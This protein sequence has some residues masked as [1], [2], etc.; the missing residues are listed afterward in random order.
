[1]D[2]DTK[3]AQY[4]RLAEQAREDATRPMDEKWRIRMLKLADAYVQ[5][6]LH[7]ASLA[8]DRPSSL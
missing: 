5:A 1:M 7:F 2:Y 6:S 4:Q 3:A 8:C